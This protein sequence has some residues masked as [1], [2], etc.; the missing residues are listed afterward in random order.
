MILSALPAV[1]SGSRLNKLHLL[2][3]GNVIVVGIQFDSVNGKR[4]GR[5]FIQVHL[6][7]IVY[8]QV[9]VLYAVGRLITAKLVS[10][11]QIRVVGFD[12]RPSPGRIAQYDDFA[13]FL[14]LQP[15]IT[16]IEVPALRADKGQLLMSSEITNSHAT[17]L[18]RGSICP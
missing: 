3:D 16:A 18:R 17:A 13:I 11:S 4:V 2:A 5:F 15:G 1:F 14:P 6:A 9:G 12:D 7:V 10:I 8:K